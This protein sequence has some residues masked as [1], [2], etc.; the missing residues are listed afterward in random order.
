MSVLVVLGR[1]SQYVI[2]SYLTLVSSNYKY[3]FYVDL[4]VYKKSLL[5]KVYKK[6]VLMSHHKILCLIINNTYSYTTTIIGMVNQKG[7][8]YYFIMLIY[9]ND[10]LLP[11]EEHMVCEV[12]LRSVLI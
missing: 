7:N 1:T 12:N 5:K 10:A 4:I 9:L 3:Y 6:P 8:I 2:M 11:W